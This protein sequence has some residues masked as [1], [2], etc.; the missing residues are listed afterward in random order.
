MEAVVVNDTGKSGFQAL[1]AA[2]GEGGSPDSIVAYVFDLLH[3]NGRDLDKA[4]STE[5]K[6]NLQALLKKSKSAPALRYSEHI[7]GNGGE[8]FA[9]ACEHGS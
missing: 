3:L 6:E 7:E 5:R 2:L 1:Q 9:K 4:A 8:M